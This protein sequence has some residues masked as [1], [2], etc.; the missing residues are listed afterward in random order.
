MK[1]KKIFMAA[2]FGISILTNGACRSKGNAMDSI[3]GKDGLFA[4]METSKGEIALEL[5]YKDAPL[6]VCNFVRAFW[7]S[8]SPHL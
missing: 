2:L 8:Q 5:Y 1:I 6:T 7:Q 3:K 4:I